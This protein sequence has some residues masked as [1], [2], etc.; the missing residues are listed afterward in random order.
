MSDV[1]RQLRARYESA[2]NAVQSGVRVL[3][4]HAATRGERFARVEPKHLRVGIDL[5]KAE[6]GGLARLL[7]A[8]GV[9]TQEE[10]FSAMAEA[11]EEEAA[12]YER[13]VSALLGRPVGLG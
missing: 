4:E 7:I 9:F 13:E 1:L 2:A 6:Q 3:I 10:Y 12:R 11:A 8:K 5:S